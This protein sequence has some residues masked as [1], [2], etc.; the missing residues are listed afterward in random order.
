MEDTK[1]MKDGPRVK[2][3]LK[4]GGSAKG[5]QLLYFEHYTL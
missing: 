2:A 1:A 3:T 5:L 4:G